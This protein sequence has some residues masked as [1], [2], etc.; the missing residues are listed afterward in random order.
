MIDIKQI[1]R[2]NN[3]DKVEY[4]KERCSINI[5]INPNRPPVSV[6]DSVITLSVYSTGQVKCDTSTTLPTTGWEG[7]AA[8]YAR[9]LEYNDMVSSLLLDAKMR[10]AVAE[11]K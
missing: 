11:I 3:S 1:K 6:F 4:G 10:A 2:L 9:A 8:A 7:H 5:G